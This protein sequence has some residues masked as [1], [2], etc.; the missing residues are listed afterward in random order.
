MPTVREICKE[1]GRAPSSVQQLLNYLIAK[2]Y[3]RTDGAPRGFAFID[4]INENIR[5]SHIT[6]ELSKGIIKPLA[7]TKIRWLELPIIRTDK[8]IIFCVVL[9]I[10]K[11]GLNI[12]KNDI[13][14]LQL[15]KS[16]RKPQKLDESKV[17]A[18]LK[19]L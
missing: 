16:A 9:D 4:Q 10:S 13:L 5:N 6:H 11:T 17:I 7:K 1:L 12:H 18:I 8:E 3:I 15:N 2:G 19:I 14:L